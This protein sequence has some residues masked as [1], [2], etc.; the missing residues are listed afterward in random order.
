MSALGVTVCIVL[1]QLVV[2][3]TMQGQTYSIVYSFGSVPNDG[4]DPMA[5][6]VMDAKGNLNGTTYAGGTAG[7]GTVFKLDT[8]GKETVLYSFA[9][10]AEGDGAHPHAGLAVDAQ[11]NLYGTTWVGG[12]IEP[13]QTLCSTVF[14]VDAS[15]KE[16]V[17]FKFNGPGG[18][19]TKPS[20]LVLDEQ[21]NLYGT[22]ALGGASGANKDGTA[23]RLDAAGNETILHTF[24]MGPTDGVRPYGGVVLDAEGNLYGTTTRGGRFTL[25]P[26]SVFKLDTTGIETVLYRFAGSPDGANPYAGVVLDGQGNMYGTTY[27]GGAAGHGTVFKVDSSGNET[28]LYSFTGTP[29]GAGPYAGV[30]LDAQG[31][32]YGTTY[33]GGTADYGTVFEINATGN[34]T[35][36][37][38]FGSTKGDG[39]YPYAGLVLDAQGLYGTTTHGGA[40]NKGTVFKLTLQ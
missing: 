7:Y 37:H 25:F 21:G 22:T 5:G 35:V 19:G 17:L 31:N 13:N 33:S 24:P 26:G 32:L 20:G 9:G 4:S 34:E 39:K 40:H 2:A 12:C 11:D 38:S 8:T 3:S 6:L 29:D 28:V 30:V 1:L 36:L 27:G 23:F 10:V 15:G 18:D 16:T 14:K